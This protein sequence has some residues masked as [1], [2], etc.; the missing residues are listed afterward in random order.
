LPEA[1]ATDRGPAAAGDYAWALLAGLMAVLTVL[2][3]AACV[4]VLVHGHPLALLRMPVGLLFGYWVGMGAWR[5]T[6]W[7]RP[8]PGVVV[9]G[10]PGLSTA[11]AT[12]MVYL[13]VACVIALTLA[14]AVQAVMG[15]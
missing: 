2:N 13:C 3:M 5:R 8:A 10:G 1:P 15:L 14:Q 4:Y 9:V 12:R 6:A 7:G 11:G